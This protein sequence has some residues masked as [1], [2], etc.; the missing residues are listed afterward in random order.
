[1][2]SEHNP[3]F[4]NA[5]KKKQLFIFKQMMAAVNLKSACMKIQIQQTHCE[6]LKVYREQTW[7]ALSGRDVVMGIYIKNTTEQ[8]VQSRSDMCP[9]TSEFRV[10]ST[11]SLVPLPSGGL[12]AQSSLHHRVGSQYSPR[13]QTLTTGFNETLAFDTNQFQRLLKLTV[14]E[15][16][17][18]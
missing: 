1:M 2:L 13:F 3:A 9:N 16:F 11:L 7:Q 14:P 15:I 4:T 8:V 17:F 12:A 10:Q 6:Y 5:F 18:F